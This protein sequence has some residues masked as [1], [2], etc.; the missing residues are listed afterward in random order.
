M[1]KLGS[2]NPLNVF[3]LRELEYSP[4]HFTRVNF[5]LRTTTKQ[6]SDWVYENLEGRFCISD[7]YYVDPESKKLVTQKS[8][9][10]E[11]A[12]E[13]SMFALMLD[14]INVNPYQ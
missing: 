9:A 7:Y 2:V 10:F 6:I 11:I 13:A 1:I 14:Q 12:A 8:A 3:G 4:P 5:D